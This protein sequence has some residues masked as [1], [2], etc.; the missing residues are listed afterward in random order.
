MK[1]RLL[2]SCVMWYGVWLF[3]L[4]V[5]LCYCNVFGLNVWMCYVFDVFLSVSVCLM[6]VLMG[7]RVF[8]FGVK[9]FVSVFI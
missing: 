7:V 3:V 5:V 9:L 8:V 6:S 2:C 1:Y 4:V